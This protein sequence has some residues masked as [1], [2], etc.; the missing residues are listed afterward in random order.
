MFQDR[1]TPKCAQLPL[2]FHFHPSDMC[3]LVLYYA[4]TILFFVLSH[5]GLILN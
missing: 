5:K 1:L 2:G 4:I 3:A